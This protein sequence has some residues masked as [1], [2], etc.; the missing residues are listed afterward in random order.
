MK[1]E[2]VTVEKKSMEEGVC[3]PCTICG[4]N[5]WSFVRQ[6]RDLLRP[7]VKT[8]FKLSRCVH[9]GHVQQTPLP[10]GHELRAAYSVE[11][12][13]YRIAWKESGWPIWKILRELTTRRRMLRLKR[14]GRGRSLLEVGCGAGDFLYAAHRAGWMVKAV[15]YNDSLVDSLRSELDLDVRTG[16]LRPGLWNEG[17]FDVVALWN[18]LE[19]VPN[20]LDTLTTASVYLRA[21]GSVLLQFPTLEGV[22]GGR[23]FGQYW[24]P[25]DLPRHLN[26][27][28]KASLAQLCKKAGME[29][30]IYET[31]VLSTAW[32]YYGSTCNYAEQSKH[33]V[34]R[35]FRFALP[36]PLSAAALPYATARAWRGHGTEAFAVAI[37]R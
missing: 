15:E 14:C 23:W 10:N 7:V 30:T 13:H 27:F 17:E 21:G 6:G 36:A 22:E 32:C 35:L 33:A 26:F 34:Q 4:E 28:S 3:T 31:P 19:H 16:E 25:L 29:L 8:R 37:K 18:V 20:P 24:A 11:Y 12:P 2:S 1:R 9:C 5:Q